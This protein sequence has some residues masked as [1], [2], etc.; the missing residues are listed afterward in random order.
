VQPPGQRHLRYVRDFFREAIQSVKKD[1]SFSNNFAVVL[2][3]TGL[4]ILIQI[5]IAPILTRLYGPVAYGIYSLFNALSTNFALLST[6]R[7]PQAFL[8]PKEEK[9]FHALLRIAL[10]SALGF[11]VLIFIVLAVA[12]EPVLLALRA[13]KLQP[14]YYLIPVMVFL[15]AL[16][17]IIGNW[18]YR[19][20]VFKKSVAIDTSVL[21]GV[22]TF[23]LGFGW[24][25][26]G[27]ALGLVIGDMLGKVTGLILSWRLIIKHRM[28]EMFANVP[29]T[30]LKSTLSAYRQYPMYNLPGVWC[31]M[32]SDQLPIFFI[33]S[34]F[35][36]AT[37]GLLSFAVSMLDLPKRL[38]AYSIS[39]V[40]YKKAVDL[41]NSS[42][43]A[44]QRFV[45]TILYALLAVCVIPYAVV[46]AFGPELFSFVFG[47]EWRA[48]GEIAAYLA[49]YFIVELLYISMDSMYYVL[50]EEKRMFFFQVFALAGRFAVL[51]TATRLSLPV[52]QVIAWL[53]AFNVMLYNAQL[54]YILHLLKLSWIKHISLVILIAAGCIGFMIGLKSVIFNLL[55]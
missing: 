48:S 49:I 15:I 36:L 4:N 18:Q 55:S 5:L 23:N 50:R 38:F 28:R 31:N 11:S 6:L 1:G 43:Q 26:Q 52:E 41:K 20:N 24:L 17:Q 37:L 51:F 10:L 27:M 45:L 46:V 25:S 9:D 44:L 2:S 22:R 33:A 47:T 3:G 29:V 42:L 19:M 53:V 35:G 30:R 40:F 14:Y 39:S 16:N 12:G 13:E 54:A 32:L 34:S 8:L 21:I 7:L